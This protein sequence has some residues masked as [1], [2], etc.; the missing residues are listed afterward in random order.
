MLKLL[1]AGGVTAAG[2]YALFE[3]PP[4]LNYSWRLK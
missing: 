1:A 4:W 3:Y 2:G